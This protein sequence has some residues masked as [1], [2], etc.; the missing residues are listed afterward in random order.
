LI[1][2]ILIAAITVAAVLFILR[3]MLSTGIGAAR[4][5]EYDL[6]VYR[7]QI[8]ELET[9]RERGVISAEEARQAKVEIERRMLQAIRDAEPEIEDRSRGRLIAGLAVAVG[10]PVAAGLMYFSMG[11]PE[12]PGQPLAERTDIPV[13]A[14]ELAARAG[15]Q[16]TPAETQEGLESVENMVG[17]LE[18]R[19]ENE[20][21]DFEGWMLL[22]RS[23]GVMDRYGDAAR[24]YEKAAALPE[25]QSDPA[26]HMQLGEALIFSSGGVVTEQAAAAFER[27]LEIDGGHPGARYYLALARGQAGDL[28]GA[29]DGWVALAQDSPS[30]APWMPALR[31]RLEEVARDLGIEL[32]PDL[33]VGTPPMPGDL[34]PLPGQQ[35]AEAPPAAPAAPGP[36]AEQMQAAQEMSSEDRQAMIQG[37]VQRLADRLAEEPDDYEGW[38]RLARAYGVMGDQDGAI[39]AYANAARLRPDDVQTRLMYAGALLDASEGGPLPE[40]AVEEFRAVAQLDPDNPD[41]LWFLGRA[42]AEAG[43]NDAALEKWRRLLATQQPGSDA[44]RSIEAQIQALEQQTQ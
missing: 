5:G 11:R 25:A 15:G 19:L 41:A 10:L 39:D 16:P 14:A 2:W 28:Q 34:P 13:R 42:D 1:L 38:M 8:D 26:P 30:D 9:D 31:S 33:A 12:L 22:G 44:Y 32:D 6:K 17:S 43:R 23:Y 24:A 7:S 18:T 20:P 4:R 3:P 37:M 27:T 29:F 35:M 21:R 40:R 36:T